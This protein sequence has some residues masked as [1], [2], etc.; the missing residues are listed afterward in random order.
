MTPEQKAKV[1]ACIESVRKDLDYILDTVQEAP[2]CATCICGK[3]A[4]VQ[5]D[6]GHATRAR[7]WAGTISWEEHILAWTRYAAKY[8]SRYS[9][10]HIAE[11][12]GGFN[13]YDLKEYLGHDPLTYEPR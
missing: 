7:V 5:G 6:M 11:D 2:H 1:L 10:H 3:R 8:G 12:F 13:Y 9:A 4:P